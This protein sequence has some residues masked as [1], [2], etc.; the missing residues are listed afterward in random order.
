M[1]LY[2]LIRIY[3]LHLK[4]SNTYIR[5]TKSFNVSWNNFNSIQ[6]II[7]HFLR[8]DKNIFP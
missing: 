5:T 3:N 4:H 6:R 2:I 1:Y 7:C 8:V